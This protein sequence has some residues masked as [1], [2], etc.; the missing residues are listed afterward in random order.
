MEI[1]H[2]VSRKPRIKSFIIM[3]SPNYS[4]KSSEYV[5]SRFMLF[6]FSHYETSKYISFAKL[7]TIFELVRVQMTNS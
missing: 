5:V 4:R 7:A 6:Q 3:T 2:S 1:S